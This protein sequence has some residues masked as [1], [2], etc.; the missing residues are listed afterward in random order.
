M[1]FSK[2]TRLSSTARQDFNSGMVTNLVSTDTQ[3]I[4]ALI[5]SYSIYDNYWTFDCNSWTCCYCWSCCID[6]L[7]SSTKITNGSIAASAQ[8]GT[9]SRAKLIQEIIA[10]IMVLKFC[11]WE[12]SFYAKVNEKKSN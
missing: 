5:G 4:D 11:T 1:I 3:R 7:A 10:G 2:A 8:N 6:I 9:D 12:R